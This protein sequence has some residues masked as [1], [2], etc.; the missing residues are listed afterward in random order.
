MTDRWKLLRSILIVA[1]AVALIALPFVAAM[2]GSTYAITLA[3]RLLIY[4]MVATGLN[5]IL[6]YG[7]LVSFGHAAYFGLGGYT[8]AILAFH[9]GEGTSILGFP[10]TN[11]ALVA[12]PLAMVVSGLAALVFGALS[13]RTSGV[14]FIMITLAFAQMTYYVFVALKY[15]G[16]DDGLSLA[17]RNTLGGARIVDAQ[18]FYFVC[19][20][21]LALVIGVVQRMTV[22]RFG[23]V[24][25]GA[26]A[27][28][29]RMMAIGYSPY[30]YRLTAFVIAGMTAGLGGALW[31]NLAR[32]VSPDMMAWTKSGDFLAMAILG[33]LTSIAGPVI[34]AAAFILIESTLSGLTEYWQVIFGPIVVAV[35][36]FAPRGLWGMLAGKQER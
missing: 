12:W 18:T 10:G 13:L 8:V 30:R 34:G 15:Y 21:L 23:M 26:R 5:L 11:E 2:L 28:E 9:L 20:A 6:G 17:R 7:G 3:T 31:A 14:Y 19:L 4:A 29:R 36:L 33:G 24:L 32:F 27:D 16:G 1:A 35:A 25:S 22:S